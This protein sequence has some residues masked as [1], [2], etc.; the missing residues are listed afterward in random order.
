[1]FKQVNHSGQFFWQPRLTPALTSVIS[2]SWFIGL[3]ARSDTFMPPVSCEPYQFGCSA[4]AKCFP[5]WAEHLCFHGMFPRDAFL[6]SLEGPRPPA[7][8]LAA[9]LL[10]IARSADFALR[11]VNSEWGENGFTTRYASHCKVTFTTFYYCSSC[12]QLSSSA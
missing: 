6:G 11:P 3:R 12:L 10:A 7:W 9:D 8:A 5:I 2:Y 4:A 1:M